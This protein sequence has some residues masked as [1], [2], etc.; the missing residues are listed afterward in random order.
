MKFH[1]AY[2]IINNGFARTEVDKIFI[3]TSD[4]TLGIIYTFNVPQSV[5]P[6]GD[7][8]LDRWPVS[9]WGFLHINLRLKSSILGHGDTVTWVSEPGGIK[10]DGTKADL[11][12]II[13][14]P[15]SVANMVSTRSIKL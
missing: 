2:V 9:C 5:Q 1:H 7:E 12:G 15:D 10:K 14:V 8:S 13:I 3:N 11:S 6:V 4:R